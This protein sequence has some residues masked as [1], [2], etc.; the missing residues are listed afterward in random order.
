MRATSALAIKMA[1]AHLATTAAAYVDKSF[2]SYDCM[3]GM[4]VIQTTWEYKDQDDFSP[5]T[6]MI[7][8][9]TDGHGPQ[10]VSGQVILDTAARIM[11]K[12]KGGHGS[13]GTNYRKGNG[14]TATPCCIR[15]A[16]WVSWWNGKKCCSQVSRRLKRFL[17][18]GQG[19]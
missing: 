3:Y 2:T 1:I 6:C 16:N 19:A 15:A 10:K 17:E 7:K 8:Y 14:G 13:M 9:R 18:V 4:W 12:C 5:G 11:D